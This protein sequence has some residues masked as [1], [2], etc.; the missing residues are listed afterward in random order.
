M[1]LPEFSSGFTDNHKMAVTKVVK[2][3]YDPNYLLSLVRYFMTKKKSRLLLVT[4]SIGQYLVPILIFILALG[5]PRRLSFVEN[6]KNWY[7][8]PLNFTV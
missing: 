6:V 4:N 1:Y 7:N 3:L 8:W 2:L 5:H